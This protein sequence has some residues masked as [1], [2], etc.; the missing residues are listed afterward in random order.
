[1]ILL[2]QRGFSCVALMCAGTAI[3]L[4]SLKNMRRTPAEAGMCDQFV[5]NSMNYKE[6][7]SL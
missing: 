7:Y 2:I 5:S 1:M 6:V 4:A 3:R